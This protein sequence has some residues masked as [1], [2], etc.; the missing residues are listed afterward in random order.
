MTNDPNAGRF[1]MLTVAG[2]NPGQGATLWLNDTATGGKSFAI[3]STGGALQIWDSAADRFFLDDKGNVYVG[4]ARSAGKFHVMGKDDGH[5]VIVY[6]GKVGI[7]TTTPDK[8]PVC[9]RSSDT[10]WG[11]GI[12]LDNTPAAGGKRYAMTSNRGRLTISD[13]DN[14]ADRL[15][16]D[17]DGRA[18][19]GT[20]TPDK[21]PVCI[22]S[23]DTLWG[24]GISLDNTPATGGKRYAITSNRGTLTISDMDNVADRLVIDKSGNVGIGA[25][26][27]IGGDVN[28]KGD[29]ILKG[30]DCAE[31]FAVSGTEPVDPGTVMVIA[32]EG[33]LMASRQA[34][35][36]RVAGVISGAGDLR[37]G[38][39]LDS[40]SKETGRLPLA[41]T[42]KVYCKVDADYGPVGVGDLL[43][44]SPTCGH[45][46]KASDCGK[47]FGTV[48]GKA[49]RGLEAGKGLIPILVALQ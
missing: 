22:L 30:A 42:G 47:A 21:L 20:T 8:L 38:I 2:S 35:D 24:S 33:S 45:A 41:M 18:G 49:L 31:E 15:V 48:I 43:T 19:I 25:S 4:T 28:V 3:R 6:D 27:N 13:M 34:Y 10:L 9:V 32:A 12:S 14:T 5:S 39:I 7:G 40:Q 37:P 11:S 16:I 46:M 36:K 29:V 17:K 44:T 26:L 23:S 1:D